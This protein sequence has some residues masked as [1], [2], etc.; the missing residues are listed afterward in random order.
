MFKYLLVSVL[1]ISLSAQGN[2][3]E[4][5][6]FNFRKNTEIHN[7]KYSETL[8]RIALENNVSVAFLLYLNESIS[9]PDRIQAGQQIKIPNDKARKYIKEQSKAY[10]PLVKKMGAMKYKDRNIAIKEMIQKDWL[11]IP[12]LLQALKNEDVEIRENAR[13]AL[14]EIHRKKEKVKELN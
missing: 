13:E 11:A 5:S 10:M 1:I 4:K 7:I 14:K 8:A 12:V 2:D 9:N 3:K 6:D